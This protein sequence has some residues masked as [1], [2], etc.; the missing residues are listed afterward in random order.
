M[1][2]L[3]PWYSISSAL[4]L[5]S[6]SSHYVPRYWQTSLPLVPHTSAAATLWH[7]AAR[8]YYPQQKLSPTE[9]FIAYAL[10]NGNDW[11]KKSWLPVSDSEPIKT[12]ISQYNYRYKYE[13]RSAGRQ[14]K[15]FWTMCP[16][17]NSHHWREHLHS[18]LLSL[19]GQRQ[20]A[21]FY[22]TTYCLF[23]SAAS[24]KSFIFLQWIRH[25]VKLGYLG[26]EVQNHTGIYDQMSQ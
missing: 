16:D 3:P 6:G 22:G 1:V 15:L 8:T 19:L 14:H 12:W 23:R 20:H 7:A 9:T 24:A 18:L 2:R 26:S 11:L 5:P 13:H 4:A 10:A 25:S 21:K 17:I